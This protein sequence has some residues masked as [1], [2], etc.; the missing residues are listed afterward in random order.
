MIKI[1][2]S[3]IAFIYSISMFS[4]IERIEPPHWWVGFEDTS[5]QLLIKGDNISTALP[6]IKYH[7]ITIE[8]AQ[9][10]ESP[11][12]LFI[13]LNIKADTKPGNFEI[14]FKFKDQKKIRYSYELKNRKKDPKEFRGFDSSDVIY[15]ITPDRFSNGDASNDI[16]KNLKESTIDRKDNYARHGGDIRGII[17]HLDYINR[18]GFTAIWP[19][20]LLIN[21][22]PESSYHG[23][24]MTDFYKVDPR[25]GTLDEYIELSTKANE[26]GIKLIMD[27]VANH[28]GIEHWWMSDLPFSNWV[29]Y[30]EGFENH[31][32]LITS[33]HRRTI[34]QDLYASEKDKERMSNGW[35]VSAMPDL[36]QKNFFL[37]K[38]IT[39]NSI[40]WIETLYLGG[41]RQDT[42]P[43]AD[44]EFMS[45]WA[46]RIMKEYPNFNIVG[47]EWSYNPLLVGY[48]QNGT[49]NKDGYQSNLK[50]TMDFPMQKNMIDALKGKESWGSGL[51]K[52]YEGLANDFY[53][54]NPQSILMFGDN[55]DMDRIYTQLDK[56]IVL[57]KMALSYILTLPRIPQIYYG[58]EV[59]LD[60]SSHRGDH[61]LIRTD[62]PGGWEG[63]PVNGF[64]GSGLT[65][66]QKEMQLFMKKVL[67]YRKNSAA[68]HHGKTIHFAPKN[69]VYILFR[70]I[71][72]ETVVLIL[73][74]NKSKIKW[75]LQ[76]YDEIGLDGKSLKNIITGEQFIWKNELNL[77]A[78]G[79]LLLTTKLN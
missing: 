32:T 50:S 25:F 4:Q 55:H 56:D 76:L 44:K 16:F 22:M 7:G 31:E 54:P 14:T 12:Y 53:Y 1:V 19:T 42:Y 27:Q 9:K 21:D 40:W 48:W 78:K 43:Y 73:N 13:D 59:L 79:A 18:M 63:D 47:E 51:V 30:Q 45:A 34:N 61:G 60:N 66:K 28:C 33:S 49:H 67:N 5:L 46:G 24:A 39:Q 20:P 2:V 41:I 70:I 77:D 10:G 72:D 74:K 38:Y 71:E 15:L 23:Y 62:F 58:T 6:E 8:N 17:N 37:A 35:F 52:I 29:N 3:V 11:N 68:I 26:Y 69:G 75:D 57:T 64:T 36:N 65:E